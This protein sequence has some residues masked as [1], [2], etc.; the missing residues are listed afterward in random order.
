MLFDE[1][2]ERNP[3]NRREHQAGQDDGDGL[4][5]LVRGDQAGADGHAQADADRAGN[6][7][8]HTGQGQDRVARGGSR[9]GA[10]GDVRRQQADQG[11]FVA[12]AARQ[13]QDSDRRAAKGHAQGVEGNEVADLGQADGEST[14]EG[15]H[16]ASDHEFGS[17]QGE[18]GQGQEVNGRGKFD[19]G[20]HDGLRQ[21]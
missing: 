4:A 8:E 9:E 1:R 20:G 12:D 6:A 3:G 10:S 7:H 21:G 19:A 17:D 5:A 11:M 15:R 13:Q 18:D 2:G 16:H 14:G